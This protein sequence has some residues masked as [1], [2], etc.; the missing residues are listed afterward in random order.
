MALENSSQK[1]ESCPFLDFFCGRLTFS[2]I[3]ICL[4]K[5]IYSVYSNNIEKS[6]TIIRYVETNTKSLQKLSGPDLQGV[7][8]LCVEALGV[9]P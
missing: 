3:K 2:N 8:P 6:K 9:G 7:G 1:K 5:P 4:L